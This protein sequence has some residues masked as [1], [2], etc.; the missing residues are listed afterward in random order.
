MYI[1]SFI[2]NRAI[3]NNTELDKELN[4]DIMDNLINIITKKGLF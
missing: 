3:M 1:F 2:D 4:R